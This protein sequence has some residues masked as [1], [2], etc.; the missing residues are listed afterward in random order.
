MSGPGWRAWGAVAH[1]LSNR[2]FAATI[3]VLG[4]L[5]VAAIVLYA[6][7]T[8]A[9]QN[10]HGVVSGFSYVTRVLLEG[11]NP[12]PLTSPAGRVT[13]DVV[14]LTGRSVVA[15]ATGA[16]ASKLVET[17]IKRGTG[18]ADVRLKGHIVICG[19]SA[20]GVEILRELHA[21]EV[22]DDRPVAI[23]AQLD[24][25]PTRDPLTV[26][27]RGNPTD[28]DDLRR[29]GIERA[30]TA[31]IL[32]DESAGAAGDADARTLL[33]CLA[34]E[35][36]NAGCYTCVEVLRS[37]NRQH[38]QRTRADELVV[39]AELTGALLA[40]SARTHGLT[41][42]IGD[43]VTHPEGAELYGIDLPPALVGRT[44]AEALATLKAEHGCLAVAVSERRDDSRTHYS[45]NPSAESRL[46]EGDRLLVLSDGPP[47][48]S[49]AARR[50]GRR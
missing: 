27:V 31:I 46:A 11:S 13:H 3:A 43:L 42:V 35:S 14:M 17:V 19:W 7:E 40:G 47:V 18:M 23:L 8:G 36:L 9:N 4:V 25:S 50:R 30:S 22:E 28:A 6:A 48:F 12:W 1:R 2:L 44:F 16:L 39:S 5:V 20:K 33:A 21:R 10:V 29:A 32:A 34:V 26:F 24:A 41:R 45:V 49:R 37:E 38:F 15:L